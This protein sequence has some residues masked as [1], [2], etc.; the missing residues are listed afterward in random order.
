MTGISPDIKW[1][2]TH[3]STKFDTYDDWVKTRED[4][5]LRIQQ[6]NQVNFGINMDVPPAQGTPTSYSIEI[7]HGRAIDSG[8][9]GIGP[10]TS[11][12][13][14][15]N[16]SQTRNLHTQVTPVSGITNSYTKIAWDASASRW[17]VVQHF[18]VS[19]NWNQVLQRYDP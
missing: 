8:F 15:Y 4:A 14:P 18:P 17:K 11:V 16:N 10:K 13:N 7:N 6:D 9:N 19:K 5:I 12:V 1:S 2:P 3:Y